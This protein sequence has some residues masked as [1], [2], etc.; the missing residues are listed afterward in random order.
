MEQLIIEDNYNK[1]FLKI[2]NNFDENTLISYN[3]KDLFKKLEHILKSPM[4]DFQIRVE[5]LSFLNRIVEMNF[6]KKDTEIKS[7]F[8][9]IMYVIVNYTTEGN[10]SLLL[11]NKYYIDNIKKVCNKINKN[12]NR[13]Q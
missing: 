9:N 2:A 1:W 13:F 8:N 7:Y 10:V 5:V 11:Y 3:W 4:S 6:V 12:I